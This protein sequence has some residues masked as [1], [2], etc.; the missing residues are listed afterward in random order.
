M[1]NQSYGDF[2][3]NPTNP[4]YLHPNE[5]PS[6][7]LVTP[8]LDK[9]NY[10]AWARAMKLS[11][12]SK[13]KLGFV[14]GSI[15]PPS[16]GDPLHQAWVRCNTMVLSWIQRSISDSIVRSV[17][18]FDKASDAWKDLYK[19]FSQGDMFRIADL[20]EDI[21]KFQ[22]G[23]LDVSEYFTQLKVMWD[24][25]DTLRSTPIC[26]CAIRCSCGALDTIKTQREQD[27]VIRFLKG[28]NE[29]YA[30]VRSQI[31]MIDPLPDISKA[32]SMVLQ[33]E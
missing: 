12:I 8:L 9:K 15:G 25:L 20:Q 22:Q 29:Q 18:W 10:H 24:E 17:L 4:Y 16:T 23:N 3:T 27:C 26:K 32:F 28:L 6:P 14:D 13:N 19:R 11:L 30:H 21:C 33:Q 31:M 5:N 1:E 7:V 2:A